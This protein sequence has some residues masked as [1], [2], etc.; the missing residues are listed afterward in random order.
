LNIAPQCTKVGALR[1]RRR[2]EWP[3]ERD[4]ID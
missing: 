2:P 1:F 3:R 4:P